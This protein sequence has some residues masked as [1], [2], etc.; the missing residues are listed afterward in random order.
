MDET[1]VPPVA[2]VIIGMN[3]ERCLPECIGSVLE[4]DYPSDKKRILYVDGGSND[5]SVE[6][7]RHFG[8]VEIIELKDSSPTPGRGRNVGLRATQEP[9]IQFID[10]DTQLH[11][12]WFQRAIPYLKGEVIAV[13]GIR[14]ERFPRKNF[15]HLIGDIEWQYEE[16]PCRYFGGDALVRREALEAIGGYDEDLVAGED[17]DLSSRLR[18]KGGV[19]YRISEVMT[20]HDLNMTTL[21]QYLRRAFRTGHAYS[22]IGLRYMT[23]KEKLWFKELLRICGGVLLPWFLIALGFVVGNPVVGIVAGLAVAM[24]PFWKAFSFKRRFNLSTSQALLYALHLSLVVYPQCVGAL[25]YGW[26]L[27]SGNPLKN[28][29]D[30]GKDRS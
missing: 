13:C 9:L 12:Q 10:G 29:A 15:Y 14:K 2:V 5:R 16:G 30:G 11:P 17:P 27:L 18:E 7:A 25:R 19:I 8:K 4:A 20:V 28:R 1:H 24:R 26:T 23:R 21:R 22:E 6:L 3:V